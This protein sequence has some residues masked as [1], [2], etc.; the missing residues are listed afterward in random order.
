VSPPVEGGGAP[1]QGA[2]RRSLIGRGQWGWGTN[3]IH[4]KST[5]VYV[6]SLELR[7]SHPPLSPAS[8]PLPPEPK[9]GRGTHSP[10]GEGLGESQFQRLEKKLSTLPNLWGGANQ[11]GRTVNRVQRCLTFFRENEEYLLAYM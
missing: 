4:I 10:A 8:V 7:L 3:Y 11:G 1:A 6:P 9:G 2:C 5:A